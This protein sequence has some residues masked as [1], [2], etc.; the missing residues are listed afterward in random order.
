MAVIEIAWWAAML[1]LPVNATRLLSPVVT[2]LISPG[3]NAYFTSQHNN[4]DFTNQYNNAD[5]TSQHNKADFTSQDKTDF[6]GQHDN[7][8]LNSQK[9]C[10]IP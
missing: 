8:A 1:I 3:N 2:M 6:T 4:A 9:H 5:F 7:A 10:Y